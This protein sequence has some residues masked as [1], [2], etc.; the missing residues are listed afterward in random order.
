MKSRAQSLELAVANKFDVVVIG[1]GIVGA[2]CAQD[3]ASRGLSCLLLEKEDFSSGTSSKTTKLIHG[4]LRYLEQFQ[5]RLTREL[6][7]ERALLEQLAPHLVKDFSF[8]MPIN[9][10]N[11]MFSI[12]ARLGLTLYDV[13]SGQITSLRR[14]E[15][16]SVKETLE[17]APSLNNRTLSGGL[18]FHDCISD[19]SRMVVEVVKSAE[20]MGCVVV[21]Y[22]E[23]KD[24]ECE[25]G[26]VTKVVARDRYSG[27]DFLIECASLINAAGVWSDQLAS[28]MNSV[29]KNKVIPAKGTHIM[30]PLSAFETNTALFLPTEDGRYVF[31]VP[32]QKALMIG[33]TDTN[34]SGSIDEALPTTEE[35]D[36][37]LSVVNKYANKDKLN[38]SDVIAA[39]AGLRP[40]VGGHDRELANTAESSEPSASTANLSR[41]HFL[42]EGPENVVGLI[43]GKLTN[44]RILAG[45]VVDKIVAKLPEAERQKAEPS[46]THD[47]MLGGWKNK[48]DYLTASSEI[49]TKARALGVEPASLDHLLTS[50][51]AEAKQILEMIEQD[52]LLGKRISSE[53]PPLLAEVI[54]VVKNEMAVSLE[55]ILFRRIRLGLVHHKECQLAASKVAR[56]VQSVLGWDDSRVEAEIQAI[57]DTIDKHTVFESK[58]KEVV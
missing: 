4:G 26:L 44:Y 21:N 1:G 51:G 43:G 7:K 22:L 20:A 47:V 9:H 52:P 38:R 13:L 19:D 14:H 39:W 24:F 27:S 34:Y 35:I 23:A 53:F 30:V 37:L 32:W 18:K 17:A 56:L 28:K 3:A 54:Y 49:S 8:I 5:F 16:L 41:E 29:Q 57:M 31:V 36:Y 50:Y 42:F 15:N 12:K 45:H 58:K 40:L 6:C 33:T 2:G 46:K 55:D 25:N 10:E 11:K 48:S